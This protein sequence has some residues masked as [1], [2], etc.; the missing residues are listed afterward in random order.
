ML[1]KKGCTR[2]AISEVVGVNRNTVGEWI[3]LWQEGG[4]KALRVKSPG[5][6]KG[7]GQIL[8]LQQQQRIRA[9]LIEVT[10][11]Q[12]KLPFALWTREAVQ[13]LIKDILGIEMPIRTVGHYL[14]QW[15]FTPQKPLRRA[16]ER[17]A[18]KVSKWLK[19][20][21]PALAKRAKKEGAEIHWGDET[22]ICS[23]DQIGRGYA[24]KG[25]TPVRRQKG[26]KER[27]NMISSITNQGKVR[28]MFYEGSMNALR[29]LRFFRKLIKASE[30]RK[31]FLILDNLRVHH[32]KIVRAW[33][34]KYETQIEVHYLPSY[35]PD[36]NPDEYLNCDLK[37]ELS[38][39]PGSR[40]LGKLR[41]NAESH[42]NFLSEQP[43]RVS[44]YFTSPHIA[45][46]S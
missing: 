29:L 41:E 5:A 25:Q 11:D 21:Y 38:K 4:L 6:P 27:V 43:E 32:A 16:Y 46:A 26:K 28:F 20:D 19:E 36:L 31:L 3:K 35:S 18:K 12:L 2:T 15:G 10:P 14:Q 8:D 42:L 30:G 23:H 9:C 34:D 24:P 39:R 22:G 13:E 1:F 17:D 7:S 33:L 44:K 37:N 45:Y 40:Q